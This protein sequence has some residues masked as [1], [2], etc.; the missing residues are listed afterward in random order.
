MDIDNLQKREAE[1]IAILQH[2]IDL[3][4]IV[5]QLP[6]FFILQQLPNLALLGPLLLIFAMVLDHVP[7]D[8]AEPLVKQH[9]EVLRQIDLILR[10]FEDL[11]Q[12]VRDYVL[13]LDHLLDDARELQAVEVPEAAEMFEG[14]ELLGGLLLLVVLL[15][16]EELLKLLDP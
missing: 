12:R 3:I 2:F 13:L 7:E 1:F 6:C 5:E 10:E 14:V 9:G 4:R 11:E 8:R 15:H 16:R